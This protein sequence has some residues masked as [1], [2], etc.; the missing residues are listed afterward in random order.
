MHRPRRIAVAVVELV[1]AAVAVWGAFL[2][3]GSAIRDV[4][5][6]LDDGSTLTSR[7]Y[8]GDLI[9]LAVALGA[10]AAVLVIDAVRQVML[11]VAA[12]GKKP[13]KRKRPADDPDDPDDVDADHAAARTAH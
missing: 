13:R 6:H 8:E 12:K 4:T 2:L 5:V 7:V 10:L 3:W 11:G 1:V 9:G